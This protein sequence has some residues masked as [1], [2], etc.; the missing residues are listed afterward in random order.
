MKKLREKQTCRVTRR[1]RE[2]HLDCALCGKSQ[3]IERYPA[4]PPAGVAGS[5]CSALEVLQFGAWHRCARCVD[6][7]SSSL[8]SGICSKSVPQTKLPSQVRCYHCEENRPTSNY[9]RIILQ[10]LHSEESLWK[11][12]CL[13][14]KSTFY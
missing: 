6:L 1:L 8:R 10:K 11:E 12:S 4:T 7:N 13:V 14:C 3:A 9:D 2:L 5:W